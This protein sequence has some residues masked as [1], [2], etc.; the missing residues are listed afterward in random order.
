MTTLMFQLSVLTRS[1]V[2]V[3]AT[4]KHLLLLFAWLL[5]TVF[6]T[7]KI[8][9]A[10]GDANGN[11]WDFTGCEGYFSND[12]GEVQQICELDTC[13]TDP[14][15]SGYITYCI[16]E[17]FACMPGYTGCRGLHCA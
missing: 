9:L 17:L 14:C 15:G 11:Q 6:A 1:V 8:T 4:R 7:A 5:L 2:R 13:A 10:C 3:C 16:N 12:C